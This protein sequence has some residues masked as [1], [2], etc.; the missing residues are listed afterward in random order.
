ML[1]LAGTLLVRSAVL[2]LR[3]RSLAVPAGGWTTAYGD[4]RA[5]PAWKER[6]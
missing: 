6:V 1:A 4:D 5:R 3:A 2:A